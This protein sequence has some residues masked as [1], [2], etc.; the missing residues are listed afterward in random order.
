[1]N[2][3]SKLLE[4]II[5][6]RI[7]SQL[8][9]NDLLNRYQSVYRPALLKV[10]YDLLRNLDDGKTTVLVLLDLSAAFDQLDHSGVIS[11]L[12]NWIGISGNAFRW[13]ALYFKS[14]NICEVLIFANF[15][16]RKNSKITRS[17][18]SDGSTAN[19]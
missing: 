10:Q 6:K 13:F 9:S 5:A 7:R 16:R 4:N 18:V 17:T 11:L 12:E 8:Q 1:M 14:G 3:I 15:A 19:G 2:F